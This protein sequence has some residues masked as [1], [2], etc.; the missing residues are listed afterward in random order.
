MSLE[1]TI[2]VGTTMVVHCAEM[3]TLE[4]GDTTAR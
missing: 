3:V 1:L 2:A 4:Q